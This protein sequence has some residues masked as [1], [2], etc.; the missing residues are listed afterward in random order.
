MPAYFRLQDLT[1]VASDTTQR[2][3]EA[4]DIGPFKTLVVEVRKPVAASGGVLKL[5][6]A[7]VLEE[8]AF[9]DVSSLTFDLT[10]TGNEVQTFADL[11][12]YLRWTTAS[13]SSGPAQF[14]V[15]IIAREQ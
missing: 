8:D 5:Q 11:L 2:I 15:D 1:S 3:E 9:V 13:V 6:H 12:R 4:I 7:S 14:M 10:A